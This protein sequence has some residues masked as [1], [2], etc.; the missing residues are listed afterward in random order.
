MRLSFSVFRCCPAVP[1]VPPVALLLLPP[2]PVSI[3]WISKVSETNT[4]FSAVIALVAVLSCMRKICAAWLILTTKY[5]ANKNIPGSL[6]VLAQRS[7]GSSMPAH[8]GNIKWCQCLHQWLDTD[9]KQSRGQL[10]KDFRVSLRHVDVL[11]FSHFVC[12]ASERRC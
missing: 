10:N 2:L 11:T 5:S 4:L 8:W 12:F 9:P 7:P 1:A 3:V 6:N